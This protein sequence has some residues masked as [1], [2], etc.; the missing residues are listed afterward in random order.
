MKKSLVL[1]LLIFVCGFSYGQKIE[2][3]RNS[4]G[5]M[6]HQERQSLNSAIDVVNL[7]FL[8]NPS[9]IS[10]DNY[11]VT[12]RNA[13]IYRYSYLETVLNI[14]T[15]SKPNFIVY[16]VLTLTLPAGTDKMVRPY[17]LT[18]SLYGTTSSLF[19]HFAYNLTFVD[20][21]STSTFYGYNFANGFYPTAEDTISLTTFIG[22]HLSIPSS[23][24]A[25]GRIEVSSY[26]NTY[27]YSS[28]D[29]NMSV[30]DMTLLGLDA[31]TFGMPADSV[32]NIYIIKN[33]STQTTVGDNYFLYSTLGD[34]YSNGDMEIT[35]AIT[36][37]QLSAAL[38][39]GAPT[40]VELNTATGT[41]PSTA[42]AGYAV[43]I[44]DSD[45]S[46][47]LYRIESDGTSWQYQVMAK[48]L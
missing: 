41:T 26:T 8:S 29:D 38:T 28:F 35:G 12:A 22:T 2:R 23:T 11:M 13:A 17:N 7:Q 44:A 47:L 43:T 10:M 24:G 15:A 21:A 36:Q 48:A 27:I 20:F 33:T 4:S 39:D 45:G 25:G 3:V 34:I 5:G 9:E 19:Y 32:D 37:G 31:R 40:A 30:G 42:G 16:D 18:T 6:N 1:V 46:G 14:N